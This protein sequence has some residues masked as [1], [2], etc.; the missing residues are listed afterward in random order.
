MRGSKHEENLKRCS[1]ASSA[2]EVIKLNIMVK[3]KP[4]RYGKL[5]RSASTVDTQS[6]FVLCSVLLP[7]FCLFDFSIENF[8]IYF[9]AFLFVFDWNC[10]L[11]NTLRLIIAESPGT[12]FSSR[13]LRRAAI[14]NEIPISYAKRQQFALSRQ[15]NPIQSH[16]KSK[17]VRKKVI[18][19]TSRTY[20]INSS[21]S[22][23]I[24]A[25]FMANGSGS[26]FL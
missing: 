20:E 4:Q 13:V 19:R 14:A 6:S 9:V 1:L 26:R 22:L 15:K 8:Y 12:Q 16:A 23:F 3:I 25:H 17:N 5:G 24:N 21:F 7:V 18:W 11:R 10:S 2:V